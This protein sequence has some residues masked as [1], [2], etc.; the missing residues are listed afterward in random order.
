MMLK[1]HDCPE[2]KDERDEFKCEQCGKTY[3]S[4]KMLK[5]HSRTHIS[6]DDDID[7]G[8]L[9]M[10]IEMPAAKKTI[11]KAVDQLETITFLKISILTDYSASNEEDDEL[12]CDQCDQSFSSAILMRIHKR[13][14][15][16]EHLYDDGELL[17]TK[18]LDDDD[19]D[20]EPGAPKT[21]VQ[22]LL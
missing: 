11:R 18:K 14:H 5:I 22:E 7:E 17:S 19:K 8:I 16:R 2:K 20:D 3:W 12:I 9:N 21:S 10:K 15:E 6:Y 4:E 13:A 1:Y